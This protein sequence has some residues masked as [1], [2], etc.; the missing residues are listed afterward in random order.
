MNWRENT[1]RAEQ[2]YFADIMQIL[3][4]FGLDP[5]K[6]IGKGEFL[7]LWARQAAQ[8]MIL[9]RLHASARSWR[10]AAHESMQGRRIYLALQKELSGPVGTRVRELVAENAK[11]ITSFPQEVA[12]KV[13]SRAA[14]HYAEGGRSEALLSEKLFKHAVRSRA[15]LVARTEVSKA[16]TA[17]TEARAEE[18]NL[19]YYVWRSSADQRVRKG[20]RKMDGVIVPWT[21]PPSPEAL[22]G[23]RDYGHYQAGNTF[24][25][26]CYPEPL[27]RMD[28][29]QWPHRTYANGSIRMMTQS[30]FRARNSQHIGIAA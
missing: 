1:N 19:P 5:V 8:R 10:Q 20:H 23:E 4:R 11:L 21:D 15:R 26:R 12:A 29:V 22:V 7:D 16:S 2:Q 24:N 18:L 13:A 25:C 9:G 17:L 3:N 30:A 27:L 14:E 6:L 28:Q